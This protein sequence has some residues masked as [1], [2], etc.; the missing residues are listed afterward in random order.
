MERIVPPGF[1]PGGLTTAMLRGAHL[2]P[3]L[4]VAPILLGW[5]GGFGP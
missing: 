1:D 4:T 3:A 2:R 5:L